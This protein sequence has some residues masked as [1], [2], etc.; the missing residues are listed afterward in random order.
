MMMIVSVPPKELSDAGVIAKS[1]NLGS[2]R[3][4]SAHVDDANYELFLDPNDTSE[5]TLNI[6]YKSEMK[7]LIEGKSLTSFVKVEAKLLKK[8]AFI[9]YMVQYQV[10]YTL[11]SVPFPE[12]LSREMFNAFARHNGLLNSW[13]Y[14]RSQISN[15]SNDAGF[16]V[17]LPLLKI[18]A[19]KDEAINSEVVKTN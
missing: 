13:P 7:E 15:L 18:T 4:R 11:P 5:I 12:N 17:M 3:L 1:V 8:E 16:P 14:I 6:D 10:D 19:Q 2:I 9:R